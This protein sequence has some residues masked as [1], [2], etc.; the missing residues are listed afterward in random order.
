MTPD[1]KIRND[2]N[3]P[4]IMLERERKH[5]EM[6]INRKDG[7]VK[8]EMMDGDEMSNGVR[9]RGIYGAAFGPKRR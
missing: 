8:D 7:P 3:I 1:D 2:L 4:A 6:S 5:S 9:E